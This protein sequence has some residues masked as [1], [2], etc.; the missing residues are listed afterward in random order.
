MTDQ[1]DTIEAPQDAA[2][3]SGLDNLFYPADGCIMHEFIDLD[4]P[5]HSVEANRFDCGIQ[6]DSVAEFETV[7]QRLL[8][9][10]D[11]N[12]HTIDLM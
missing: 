10:I 3:E 8:R 12:A 9:V 1:D 5:S 2:E 7:G 11:A 6:T 4:R